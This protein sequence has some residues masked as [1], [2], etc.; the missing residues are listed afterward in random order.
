MPKKYCV[1]LTT[2]PP[3]PCHAPINPEAALL[4]TAFVKNVPIYE[5]TT[6]PK[7]RAHTR[8]ISK[9]PLECLL[10]GSEC[11]NT[12]IRR[13]KKLKSLIW[14][15]NPKHA[16][17]NALTW[18][19]TLSNVNRRLVFFFF[20]SIHISVP[21]WLVKKHCL[22]FGNLSAS[23]F[24][25][26]YG[27]AFIL[28][29]TSIWRGCVARWRNFSSVYIFIYLFIYLSLSLPPSGERKGVALHF[30]LTL[31]QPPSSEG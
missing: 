10:N 12:C 5:Q 19:K 6:N 14:P 16:F 24:V 15:T 17:L 7:G 29:Q 3:F 2:R 26:N 20:I 13:K 1:S 31:S 8:C 22:T 30:N 9:N 21:F 28:P 4:M 18:L 25:Q 27:Q 11:C 23:C